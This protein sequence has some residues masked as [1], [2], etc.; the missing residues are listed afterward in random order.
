MAATGRRLGLRVHA[1]APEHTI[2][3]LLVALSQMIN[4]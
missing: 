1:E 2:E 4:R 3:G